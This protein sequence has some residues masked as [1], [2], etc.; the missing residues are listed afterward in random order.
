MPGNQDTLTS[1]PLPSERKRKL[2]P[3]SYVLILLGEGSSTPW[4]PGF[5]CLPQSTDGTQ[6]TLYPWVPQRTKSW[7]M[8]YYC[9]SCTSGAA[10]RP[11][12]F[13][14]P[15]LREKEKNRA[16]TQCSG[17]S[18]DWFL[19]CCHDIDLSNDFLDVTLKAQATK[20]TIGKCNHIKFKRFCT[21]RETANRVKRQ[22]ARWEKI[23]ANHVSGKV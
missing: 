12:Q 22:S 14:G 2:D 18:R 21:I 23:F 3:T 8:A 20:A 19:S 7:Q 16:C 1:W 9:S 11:K 6:H 4:G 13:G 5:Q 15:S 10:D 17:F